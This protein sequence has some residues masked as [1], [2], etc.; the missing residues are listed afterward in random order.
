[1][2]KKDL[3][4]KEKNELALQEMNESNL[5]GNGGLTSKDIVIP[6]INVMQPMS[7]KVTAGKAAFGE[8]RDSLNNTLLG[9][10]EQPSVEF[11]PFL[12]EKTFVVFDN[13]DPEDKTYLRIEPITPDNEDAKYED[14]EKDDN[15]D[16]R[17]ISRYRT[18]TFYVL[19]TSELKLGAAV[20]YII[21]FSKTSLMAGKK[22]TTQMYVKNINSGKNPAGM[23]AGLK[24]ER[25][26]QEKK[27]WAVLDVEVTKETPVE[28]QE[29]AFKWLKT[30]KEGKAK[31]HAEA[32]SD[33]AQEKTVSPKEKVDLSAPSEY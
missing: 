19:L 12:M 33:E 15:G 23:M 21:A 27:T 24:C 13:S 2:S 30:I 14:E 1:M 25:M 10:F 20:P 6:R 7:E 3:T 26:S 31:V 11:V 17:K 5:W 32:F 22:L 29:E 4:V 18:M 9:G 8:I 16:I 28:W